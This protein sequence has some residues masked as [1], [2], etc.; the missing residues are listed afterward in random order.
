MNKILTAVGLALAAMGASAATYDW[1]SLAAQ[2]DSNLSYEAA[3]PFSDVYLFSL[4]SPNNGVSSVVSLDLSQVF[5]ITNG[6]Y[7]LWQDQ[8]TAGPSAGDVELG[9]WSFSGTTGS[10]SHSLILGNGSYYYLVTGVADG[11]GDGAGHSGIY[12]IAA[13]VLPVPEP[14][15][16]ALLLAGLIGVV[17]RR[18]VQR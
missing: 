13:A 7:S 16:A 17:V 11:S 14:A 3:G 5:D 8:G 4:S 9:S 10:T 15:S 1:G 18:R 2:V 12:S 6:N